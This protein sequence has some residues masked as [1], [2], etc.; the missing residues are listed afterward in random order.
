MTYNKKHFKFEIVKTI[1]TVMKVTRKQ[2][3]VCHGHF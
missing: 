2:A 3:T 1:M